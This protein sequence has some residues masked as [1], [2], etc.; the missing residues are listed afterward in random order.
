MGERV[1]DQARQ[2]R[3]SLTRIQADAPKPAPAT[4]LR[5]EVLNAQ[6]GC[7]ATTIRQSL[8]RGLRERGIAL[9]PWS[10]DCNRAYEENRG[11]PSAWSIWECSLIDHPEQ[12]P[13]PAFGAP[14]IAILVMTADSSS[15]VNAYRFL[16]EN[17]RWRRSTPVIGVCNQVTHFS[18]AEHRCRGLMELL[19]HQLRYRFLHFEYIP[20]QAGFGR[21]V[22]EENIRDNELNGAG[23]QAVS[24]IAAELMASQFG[25][26]PPPI[27]VDVKWD[28][29]GTTCQTLP[30]GK[31]LTAEIG[32]LDRMSSKNLSPME[33][34]EAGCASSAF[35]HPMC[36][37]S[38]DNFAI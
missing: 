9:Q 13:H 20:W 12:R 11:T 38:A 25:S 36:E 31:S 7:G 32:S 1:N 4:P 8:T 3:Q 35:T 2:L 28:R 23:M 10:T 21:H 24:R 34:G 17:E 33:H 15:L 18:W 30:T 37:V 6:V 14:C 27:M 5:I 29:C 22:D 16:K 19:E 26:S